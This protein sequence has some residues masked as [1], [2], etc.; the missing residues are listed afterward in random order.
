MGFLTPAKVQ[1]YK[2]LYSKSYHS[3]IRKST[4]SIKGKSL[5]KCKWKPGLYC[6]GNPRLRNS[7]HVSLIISSF[8]NYLSTSEDSIASDWILT[9]YYG[10]PFWVTSHLGKGSQ[11]WTSGCCLKDYFMSV[12]FSIFRNAVLNYSSITETSQK[13]GYESQSINIRIKDSKGTFK[14]WAIIS[15]LLCKISK[16]LKTERP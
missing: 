16:V 6:Y 10:R 4:D 13:I 12:I 7:K 14:T 9:F 2:D 1:V 8:S 5:L 11:D 15:F 3:K